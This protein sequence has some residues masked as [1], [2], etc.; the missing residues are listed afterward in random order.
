MKVIVTGGH[1][2][3]GSAISEDSCD[4]QFLKVGSKDCDLRNRESC[5]KFF[6]RKRDQGF[7]AVIH[8]AARVGGVKGNS[9]MLSEFFSDN[10]IINTNVLDSCVSVRMPRVISLLSTCVYPDNAT[11]PLTPDQVHNGPPHFSNFGYAYAKRMLDVQSRAIRKQHGL[12][13]ITAIPN[14]MYGPRDN[15]DIV[16]GHVIPSMIRKIWEAKLTNSSAQLWG[17]GTNL[18]EFTYSKDVADI[19]VFLLENYDGEEPVNVGRPCEISIKDLASA[20]CEKVGYD[21]NMIIW[22]K[23]QSMGQHRKPSS[24]K[25]LLELGWS[26]SYTSLEDGI[27]STVNWFSENYPRVRGII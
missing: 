19:L 18:R 16:N 14:N 23:E 9:D 27:S 1:G 10:I 17:D 2:M 6:E 24:N 3:V 25:S 20:I 8:L 15:F 12:K 22:D 7:D 5:F 4:H 21:E 13:Y 26:R 11:Y